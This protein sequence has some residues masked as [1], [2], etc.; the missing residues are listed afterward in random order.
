VGLFLNFQG[1]S[2]PAL[3]ALFT[4]SLCSWVGVGLAEK[5]LKPPRADIAIQRG[6]KGS[7]RGFGLYH[8]V[9]PADHVLIA[10]W[11]LTVLVPLTVDSRVTVSDGRWRE[12]RPF[13]RRL[14]TLGRRPL[15]NPRVVAK[16]E[17]E[18]LRALVAG[19]SPLL[20]DVP[21][22]AL[23]VFTQPAVTVTGADAA[24]DSVR[25]EDLRQWVADRRKA[26]PLSNA[27]RRELEKLVDGLAVAKSPQV[28]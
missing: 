19:E 27:Q 5:W 1:A 18:A 22:D 9:L 4:G 2:A 28:G 25:A 10:P 11:G 6:L 26:E 13:Y 23:A 3:A 21:I 15:G 12:H 16:L 8:W 24:L 14:L 20:A 17:I 7:G